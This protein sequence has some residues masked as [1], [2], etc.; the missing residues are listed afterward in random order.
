MKTTTVEFDVSVYSLDARLPNEKKSARKSYGTLRV[1]VKNIMDTYQHHVS[2]K[3][4]GA[5]NA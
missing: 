4:L 2:V 3:V 5:D 1:G